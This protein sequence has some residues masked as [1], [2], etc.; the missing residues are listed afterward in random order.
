MIEEGDSPPLVV[1]AKEAPSDVMLGVYERLTRLEEENVALKALLAQV[2]EKLP[3][4]AR[5]AL[6]RPS[7]LTRT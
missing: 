5:E 3:E 2:V 1:L 6:G 7:I 4:E